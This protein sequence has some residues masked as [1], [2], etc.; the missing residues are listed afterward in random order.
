MRDA[1]P[2]VGAHHNQGRQQHSSTLAT[3]EGG[4]VLWGVSVSCYPSQSRHPSPE[5]MMST[6]ISH[7]PLKDRLEGST[8]TT[9]ATL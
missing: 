3:T 1:R 7:G 4:S 9:T 6:K 8:P 2:A 5:F